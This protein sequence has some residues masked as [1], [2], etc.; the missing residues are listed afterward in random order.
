MFK[1]SLALAALLLSALNTQAAVVFTA[2]EVGSDVVISS[3]VGGSLDLSGLTKGALVSVPEEI[4]PLKGNL[5]VGCGSPNANG[6]CLTD[7]YTGLT[8]NTSFGTGGATGTGPRRGGPTGSGPMIGVFDQI[9]MLLIQTAYVSGDIFD[10]SSSTYTN[11]TFADLGMDTG[12]YVWSWG[13]DSV[14]LNT[15][16]SVP[17]PATVWL[18][19][20]AMLG[21]FGVA[22]R[23]KA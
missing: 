6:Y 12:T 8:L 10:V 15:V 18:F 14:T 2:F 7:R 11:S 13:S 3:G 23:K 17:V 5:F 20:S 19:G 9:D 16:S 21:L 22:R 4:N 1:K